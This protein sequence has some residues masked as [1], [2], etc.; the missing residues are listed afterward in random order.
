MLFLKFFIR[1]HFKILTYWFTRNVSEVEKDSEIFQSLKH[2]FY[3][4]SGCFI[5]GQGERRRLLCARDWETLFL[6]PGRPCNQ[7]YSLAVSEEYYL[8]SYAL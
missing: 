7:K 8:I 2:G 4:F 3:S 6:I 5:I 1:S